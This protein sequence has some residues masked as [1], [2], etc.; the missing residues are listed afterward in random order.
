MSPE[1]RLLHV[2]VEVINAA[3][4]SALMMELDSDTKTRTSLESFTKKLNKELT[5]PPKLVLHW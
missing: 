1:N 3:V 5:K 2:V 4:K